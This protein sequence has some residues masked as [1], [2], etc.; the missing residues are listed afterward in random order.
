MASK[1]LDG[2]LIK[3]AN[4]QESFT[5]QQIQELMKCMDPDNGLIYFIENYYYIR[6]PTQ[7]GV[8]MNPHEYQRNLLETFNNNRNVVAMVGRQQ[9]KCLI[10]KEKIQIRHR[11]TGEIHEMSIGDFFEMQ[12]RKQLDTNHKGE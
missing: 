1:T 5:E 4:Q 3:K 2:V 10:Y 7:G 9:G 12:Q 6:H 11:A 8:I